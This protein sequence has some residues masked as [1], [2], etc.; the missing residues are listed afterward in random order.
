LTE[1]YVSNSSVIVFDLCQKRLFDEPKVD[2]V[3]CENTSPPRKLLPG[4]LKTLTVGESFSRNPS[5]TL[6]ADYQTKL[7]DK[8]LLQAK[9]K[10]VLEEFAQ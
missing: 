9:W 8:A 7:P 4:F 1:R 10:E 3:V 2:S 5:P 6:V